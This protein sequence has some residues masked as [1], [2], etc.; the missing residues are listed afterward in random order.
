M[1]SCDAVVFGNQDGR[2]DRTIRSPISTPATADISGASACPGMDARARFTVTT[3]YRSS[4][5]LARLRRCWARAASWVSAAAATMF[6]FLALMTGPGGLEPLPVAS[7]WVTLLPDL[8]RTVTASAW[9]W[10]STTGARGGVAGP[11]EQDPES[12]AGWPMRVVA[13][14]EPKASLDPGWPAVAL[15]N[16]R[17]CC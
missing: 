9:C 17:H 4:G 5:E 6:C 3:G 8:R 15:A 10:V 13:E 1:T 7:R 16:S 2:F 12:P 14:G 11:G